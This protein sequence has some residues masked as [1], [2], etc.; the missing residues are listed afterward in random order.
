MREAL[1]GK[2]VLLLSGK[3]PEELAVIY[4]FAT[5]QP[6]PESQRG[7]ARTLPEPVL[8]DG[9]SQGG[10][11]AGSRYGF[12][13]KGDFW[14]VIFNGG[15]PFYLADT[16]GARYLDYLL[17]HPNVTNTA[18]KLEVLVT[19]EKGEA[20]AIESVQ[21]ESD[22]PAKRQYREA[23]RLIQ[24]ERRLAKKAGDEARVRQLDPDIKKL[25]ALLNNRGGMADTGE[26]AFDNVRKALRVILEQARKGG[27]EEQAFAGHLR[28]HLSI[29]F[30]CLYTQGQ[31]EVWR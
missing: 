29:G 3:T 24:S 14:E 10:T 21:P 27:A 20:R 26:R 12:R 25:N 5:G 6:L 9:P 13:K 2:L 4:R 15:Q 11:V 7:I 19:P 23:L 1:L 31:G 16:L 30:K 17:H 18:F 22:P 28:T 8:A